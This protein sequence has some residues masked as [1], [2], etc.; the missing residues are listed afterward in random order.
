MMTT[1]KTVY[2]AVLVV[3]HEAGK[4]VQLDDPEKVGNECM[5][6]VRANLVEWI[7]GRIVERHADV[8]GEDFYRVRDVTLYSEPD[9]LEELNE[10]ETPSQFPDVEM[11]CDGC[12]PGFPGIRWPTWSDG[13][14]AP[15]GWSWVERCDNC[16]RYASDGCAARAL[17]QKYGIPATEVK[18]F[19]RYTHQ[20]TPDYVTGASVAI[21]VPEPEEK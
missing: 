19:H 13:Q 15:H 7:E 16:H 18:W 2:V 14:P 5:K 11:E 8:T 9:L 1:E 10:H 12:A 20:P 21:N 6:G 3:E 17:I 4:G